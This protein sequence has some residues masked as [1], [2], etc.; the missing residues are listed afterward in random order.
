MNA[1]PI[2]LIIPNSPET[3]A[4]ARAILCDYA[5]SLTVDLSFQ[6]FET[7]LAELPGE[8]VAPGGLFLL[9]LV[10]GTVAACGAFR[11]LLDADTPNACE[12]KRL[13]VRPAFRCTRPL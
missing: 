12:M 1:P 6:Q 3:W 8:Y 11:P 10:E 13:F 4:A 9:A 2:D 7:E 5:A